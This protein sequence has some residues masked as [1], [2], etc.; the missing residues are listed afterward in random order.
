MLASPA[1]DERYPGTVRLIGNVFVMIALVVIVYFGTKE[2]VAWNVDIVKAWC[3][4]ES[5][6]DDPGPACDASWSGWKAAL[7]FYNKHPHYAETLPRHR[8]SGGYWVSAPK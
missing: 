7:A 6:Q 2:T 8:S 3:E 1:W 5:M 4:I